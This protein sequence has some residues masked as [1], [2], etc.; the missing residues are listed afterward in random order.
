MRDRRNNRVVIAFAAMVLTTMLSAPALAENYKIS[1]IRYS[2]RGEYAA[3][4][5]VN[6]NDASGRQQVSR[7]DCLK[8]GDM[9]T[10]DI[11]DLE[12]PPPAGTEVWLRIRISAG[13]IKNCR[14]SEATFL[15]DPAGARAKFHTA[16][17]EFD[18]NNCKLA[19]EDCKAR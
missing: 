7:L 9:V 18:R 2:N 10:F 17:T 15:F 1:Q 12:N 14:T 4:P 6:W 5:E 8:W 3:C 19:C 11:A 16:G 13:E